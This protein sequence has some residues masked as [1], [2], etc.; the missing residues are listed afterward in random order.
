MKGIKYVGE[1]VRKKRIESGGTLAQFGEKCG[2]FSAS[3]VNR[4]EMGKSRSRK[5]FMEFTKLLNNREINDFHSL[6]IDYYFSE[7]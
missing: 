7:D 3:M 2:G 6:L 1:F 5:F 4:I